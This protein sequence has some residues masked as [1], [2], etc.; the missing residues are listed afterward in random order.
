[1]EMFDWIICYVT[2]ISYEKLK[3]NLDK[4]L[5]L[6][7]AR[8]E[9]Q[10]FYSKT[11]ATIFMERQLIVRFI[12]KINENKDPSL[13]KVLDNI[14]YLSAFYLLDKHVG[15]FYQGSFFSSEKPVLMIRETLLELCRQMKDEAVAMVDAMAPPDFVL[16]SI[17]GTSDG[18][19]YQNLYNAMIQ[20][21]GAFE[22]IKIPKSKL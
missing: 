8:N 17:L 21:N 22:P 7:S 12:A 3:S 14:L 4:G 11:L 18:L 19:V 9:N 15:I 16:N 1:M 20:S 13:Q 2:K 6:F 10:V 5:D